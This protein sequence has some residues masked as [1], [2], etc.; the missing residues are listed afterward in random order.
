L[1]DHLA[2]EFVREGWSVKR[3]IKQIMLS[4]TYQMA[5]TPDATGDARD[6]QNLLLHRARI[7]RLQGEAIR[8]SILAISGRLDRTAFG[9][10]VPVHVTPFM[11]GRGRP[12]NDGPLDGNGRRSLYIE[13]RRNFLSPMMLAFDTP[14]PF[15]AV[16]QRNISNVPAQAL[17]MMNDPFVVE[18]ANLWAKRVVAEEPTTEARINALYLA[19]FARPPS[20]QEL[21]EGAKFIRQQGGSLG[22][23]KEKAESDER[24]WA[25][26][27]H[28][29]M[30][31]KEFVFVN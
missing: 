29:L 10:S 3:L 18:Q 16:G 24:V 6:P 15:N 11:Q 21:A 12:G 31:V 30:N 9:P 19:A 5:S 23:S 7:R 28:V 26:L 22:L 1:L 25:D 4:S 20:E 2:A 17:I 13:V 8:D 14:I 27:C